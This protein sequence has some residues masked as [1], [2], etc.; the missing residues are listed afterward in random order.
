[1]ATSRS[2]MSAG[3]RPIH[4]AIVQA[5]HS[6]ETSRK[7]VE[8]ISSLLA[9]LMQELHGGAWRF[10]ISHTAGAEFIVIAHKPGGERRA[11]PVP[12]LA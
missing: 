7:R 2:T 9:E 4:P 11:K 8:R 1:M 3:A 12:E 5:A 10:N 6:A